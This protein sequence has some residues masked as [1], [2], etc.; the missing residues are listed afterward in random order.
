MSAWV[1]QH[2]GPEIPLHFSAF[3]PDFKMLD[4][5]PTPPAT[6]RRARDIALRNGLKHVY[7]GNVH[8]RDGQSTYCRGCG[9]LLIERDWYQLG[10][11]NLDREGRCRQCGTVLAGVFEA[12]PGQ[13]G[14]ARKALQIVDA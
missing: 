12:Q 14:N 6:L 1:A 5:E 13:W 10:Q 2:L 4:V 8:D 9:G 7:T 11:W 3:H